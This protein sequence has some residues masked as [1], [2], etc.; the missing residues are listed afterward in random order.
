[1]TDSKENFVLGIEGLIK[2]KV[3]LKTLNVFSLVL[4][5]RM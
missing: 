3:S 5:E 4:Q 1:M 2:I